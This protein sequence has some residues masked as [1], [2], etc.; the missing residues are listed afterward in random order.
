MSSPRRCRTTRSAA[1][2]RSAPLRRPADAGASL[3]G[4]WASALRRAASVLQEA[5]CESP[6][7]DAELLLAAALGVTRTALFLTPAVPLDPGAFA[8]FD[9]LL[10]RRAA[11]E[12]VAYILGVRSFRMLELAVDP[13]VLIPRPETEL[14]VELGV[15][16]LPSGVRVADVG[17]GS[18]AVALALKDERPDLEVTGIDDSVDALVV[19]RENARRLG[20]DARFVHGDLL[21]GFNGEFGAVV[22]NLPYVASGSELSPEITRYEPASALFAGPDGLDAIRRL[23]TMLDGVLWV[24]LE[25]AAGQSRAVLS[26][27]AGAGFGSVSVHEDLAGIERVVV[28]RR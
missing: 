2:S 9:A 21:D 20:L 17:T 16:E 5:G 28:G 18:G 14:L 13:R 12:P 11:R 19:A 6:R 25:I 22:A 27:L 7:L 15:A 26:L 1:G 4:T 10:A 3:A 23:V 24:A 8:R